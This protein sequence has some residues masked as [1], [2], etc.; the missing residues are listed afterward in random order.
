M[1]NMT[2]QT[3]GSY[4]FTYIL[5]TYVIFCSLNFRASMIVLCMYS[6]PFAKQHLR[7]WRSDGPLFDAE[8]TAA[9]LLTGGNCRPRHITCRVQL[10]QAGYVAMKKELVYVDG[11][12]QISY[13]LFLSSNIHINIQIILCD[14]ITFVNSGIPV[15]DLWA[16]SRCRGRF[17]LAT[18]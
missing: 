5:K 13:N 11:E 4:S 12:C 8:S 17:P 3:F 14:W 2:L 16:P 1:N 6:V 7:V 9:L 15:V 18:Y 10:P